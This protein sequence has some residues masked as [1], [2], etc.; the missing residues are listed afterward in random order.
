[1]L[2]DLP[3]ELASRRVTFCMVCAD[4]RLLDLLRAEGLAEKTD[5]GE[6]LRT[7]DSVLGGGSAG[8]RSALRGGTAARTV[9]GI[10]GVQTRVR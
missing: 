10:S 2:L 6:W 5:N 4:A 8:E 7:F 9:N 3:N 1:M